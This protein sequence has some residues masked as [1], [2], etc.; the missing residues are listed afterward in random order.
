MLETLFL[1]ELFIEGLLLNRLA[2]G[3]VSGDSE[4]CS[5][6]SSPWPPYKVFLEGLFDIGSVG[7][8]GSLNIGSCLILGKPAIS[9]KAPTVI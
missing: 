4:L 5:S 8:D 2:I 9:P 6:G 7:V 1:K 3:E